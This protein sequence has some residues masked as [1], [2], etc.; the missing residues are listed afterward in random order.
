MSSKKNKRK[1]KINQEIQKIM[2][3]ALAGG[4]NKLSKEITFAQASSVRIRS[5]QIQ[6]EIK[7][8]AAI[9]AKNKVKQI[10]ECWENKYGK[11]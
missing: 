2:E 11:R 1:E 6:K 7:D 9:E 3:I 8:I 10:E 5:R 4:D